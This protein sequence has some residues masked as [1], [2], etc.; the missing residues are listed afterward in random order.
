MLRSIQIKHFAIA[1]QIELDIHAGLNV[2]TGETGAGKSIIIR[3]L[4][5][6]LGQRADS[7]VVKHGH[8]RAEIQADFDISSNPSVSKLLASLQLDEDR[9]CLLRR[10]IN[11][12]SGSKAYI[13]GRQVTAATLRQVGEHLLDIHG[14]HEHQSLLRADVQQTLVDKY[15]GL[16]DE[17]KTLQTCHRD[18]RQSMDELNNLHAEADAA[19]EKLAFLSYQV[20]EL[21]QF[22]PLSDEWDVLH[23]RHQRIHHQAE[24]ATALQNAEQ[25]LFGSAQSDTSV[26]TQ[27][28]HALL[29]LE[30]ACAI[31]PAL[32]ELTGML[33]EAQTLINESEIGLRQA[34]D[35]MQLDEAELAQIEQRYSGYLDFSRKHRVEPA[36]LYPCYQDL[37]QQLEAS[38][39]PEQNESAL[40]QRI[41]QLATEY[42]ALAKTI[43]VKRTQ[44][45]AELSG[46]ISESMQILAMQGGGFYIK[47]LPVDALP[48][49]PGYS[50]EFPFVGRDSGNEKV[51]FEVRTNPGMPAQALSRIASGGE[52]SRISLAIQLILSNLASVE[53]LVFDEVDVGVGGKTAAVIG[54]MLAELGNSRQI[55]CI[56]HLPQVAAFG[57]HH[58]H[59]NKKQLQ[60]ESTEQT[61]LQISELKQTARV[62]EIARMVGGETISDESRAHA[63]SLLKEAQIG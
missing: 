7:S 25:R 9:E 1:E 23:A 42:H 59:V 55:L 50:G 54:R 4:G 47:L 58:Y 34:A 60:S 19:H 63:S 62:Q 11:A 53:T 38:A 48:A 33:E 36:Q 30:K 44:A 5:L 28:S 8:P 61:D 35:S 15:A 27:L 18:L 52:L 51:S 37:K 21:D 17:V 24:L 40:Q 56:T 6:V 12:D 43:S 10:V 57:R 39:N 31:D 32:S 2:I 13:N 45:A 3:A 14:Q 41:H 20:N 29:E 26:N 22:S 49:A 46:K 16:S